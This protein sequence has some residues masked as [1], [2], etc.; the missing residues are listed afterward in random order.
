MFNVKVFLLGLFFY[1][2]IINASDKE[3]L[4]ETRGP[5]DDLVLSA[6]NSVIDCLR[7]LLREGNSTLGIPSFDPFE[8]RGALRIPLNLDII[9][10]VVTVSDL[11][12]EGIPDFNTTIASSLNILGGNVRMNVTFESIK[13]RSGYSLDVNFLVAKLDGEGDLSIELHNLVANIGIRAS[14]LGPPLLRNPT[15]VLSLDNA[16]IKITGFGNDDKI[17]DIISRQL[18]ATLMSLIIEQDKV[19]SYYVEEIIDGLVRNITLSDITGGGGSGI[20][21]C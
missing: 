17:S 10:G 8:I 21:N 1:I 5:I 20:L 19:I 3:I 15:F 16:N 18:E 7:A 14:T 6:L 4:R 2:A 13:L 12:L 11:T 9:S